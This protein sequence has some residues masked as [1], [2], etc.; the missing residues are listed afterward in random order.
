MKKAQVPKGWIVLDVLCYE[1]D[2][3][4]E[5]SKILDKERS[6]VFRPIALQVSKIVGVDLE[7]ADDFLEP[8][9]N[10]NVHMVTTQMEV[11]QTPEEVF[12]LI[13][14]DKEK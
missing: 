8:G 2:A 7:Y 14:L 10:A 12:R 3:D 9:C 11:S 6:L 13:Q 1:S 4:R 5:L